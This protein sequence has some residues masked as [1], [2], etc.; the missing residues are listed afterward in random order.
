MLYLL[1][2]TKLKTAEEEGLFR[3]LRAINPQLVERLSSRLFFVI[4]KVGVVKWVG[5]KKRRPGTVHDCGLQSARR[6]VQYSAS[7][8]T[9]TVTFRGTSWFMFCVSCVFPGGCLRDVR[10]PGPRRGPR[11]RGR[12]GHAA[13]GRSS[14]A[15]PPAAA[16]PA[17]PRPQRRGTRPGAR[18]LLAHAGTQRQ[19]R[20]ADQLPQQPPCSVCDGCWGRVS[21]AA[22]AALAV[23]GAWIWAP[24]VPRRR[25][26]RR[27][28]PYALPAAPGPGGCG[29]RPIDILQPPVSPP[30]NPCRALATGAQPGGSGLCLH[31]HQ[32]FGPRC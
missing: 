12:P 31:Y 18:A 30:L 3:R 6:P 9:V 21:A 29:D 22:A 32:P 14:T 17:V 19:R 5:R 1:D 20:R 23:A 24:F 13:D 28:C 26:V 10:G 25:L 16:G 7:A 4:N 8:A 27:H 15:V 11:L 2:Y